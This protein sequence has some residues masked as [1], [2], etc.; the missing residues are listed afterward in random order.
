MAPGQNG[1]RRAAIVRTGL[2]FGLWTILAGTGVADLL[3]GTV[4]AALAARVSLNLLSPGPHRVDP[5]TAARLS[6]RFL[7]QSVLAGLDVARRAFDPRL[8]LRP[9]FI[10]YPTAAPPGLF[11][12]AFTAFTSLLPGTVP[13]GPAPARGADAGGIVYHCLDVDAPV[14]AQLAAEETALAGV[15]R[16]E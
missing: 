6:L 2:L 7:L 1:D 15:I 8:P 5:A 11:R 3:V 10:V 9:G 16:D 14:A 12:S 4:V 13:A